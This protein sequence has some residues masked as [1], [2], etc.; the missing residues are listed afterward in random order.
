VLETRRT[1]DWKRLEVELRYPLNFLDCVQVIEV[2]QG[3]IE[4][5]VISS[6]LA[7]QIR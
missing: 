7:D 2:G 6:K 3:L 4:M 5:F 1:V